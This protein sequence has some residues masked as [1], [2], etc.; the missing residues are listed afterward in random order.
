M[1]KTNSLAFASIF[2]WPFGIV[3]P[4]VAILALKEIKRTGEKGKV[5]AVTSLILWFLSILAIYLFGYG[6]TN[7]W[8][9]F[10]G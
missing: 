6:M 4:I 8:L 3:G 9:W 5:Y 2:L 10:T 1:Q 7:N